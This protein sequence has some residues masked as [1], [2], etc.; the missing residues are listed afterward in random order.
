MEFSIA[1]T[2]DP[3]LMFQTI[4]KMVKDLSKLH[5]RLRMDLNYDITHHMCVP[6]SITPLTV[7]AYRE[8]E[9]EERVRAMT[10]NTTVVDYRK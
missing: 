10:T 3:D 9:Q 7:D 8:R 2:K 1:K 4:E 6:I 5:L